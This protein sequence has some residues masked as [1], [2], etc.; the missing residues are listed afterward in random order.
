[1]ARIAKTL[2]FPLSRPSVH[3]N[4]APTG[5]GKSDEIAAAG[6]GRRRH[7]RQIDG[8]TAGYA[9]DGRPERVAARY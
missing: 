7:S 3:V 4:E 6:F 2:S 5:P 9:L 1:M 8:I